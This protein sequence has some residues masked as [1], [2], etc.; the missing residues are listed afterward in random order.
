MKTFYIV[1]I[2]RV[3]KSNGGVLEHGK[4]SCSFDCDLTETQ[5]QQIDDALGCANLT[6]CDSETYKRDYQNA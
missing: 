3:I 5:R 2:G 1:A 4:C 6:L